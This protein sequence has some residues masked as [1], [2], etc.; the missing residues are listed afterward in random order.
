MKMNLNLMVFIQENIY[1]KCGAYII[2]LDEDESIGTHSIAL[3][4]NDNNLT[5]F[6]SF[7]YDHIQNKLKNS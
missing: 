5:Y 2:N 3:Y 6:N 1:L 4:V 7:G